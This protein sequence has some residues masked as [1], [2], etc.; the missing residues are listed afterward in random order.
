MKELI[1]WSKILFPWRPPRHT[2][3]DVVC[4][5]STGGSS[6][7]TSK[8]TWSTVDIR[9]VNYMNL[10]PQCEC[11][12]TWKNCWMEQPTWSLPRYIGK[13]HPGS[14]CWTVH[15]T[16]VG[17]F[18]WKAPQKDLMLS[19]TEM[20]TGRGSKICFEGWSGCD[21]CIVIC[22]VYYTIEER[23]DKD[24][25]ICRAGILGIQPDH[26]DHPDHH[27][28]F[29][30]WLAQEGWPSYWSA[31]FSSQWKLRI[32]GRTGKTTGV[33]MGSSWMTRMITMK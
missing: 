1:V 32:R 29:Q 8:S 30:K 6:F 12:W 20:V 5:W 16:C 14:H 22:P 13:W 28:L 2:C 19:K 31:L 7:C 23:S 11:N 25:G 26:S 4:S 21:Q 15:A 9:P 17:N 24:R 33:G 10:S 18:D 27:F 3:G